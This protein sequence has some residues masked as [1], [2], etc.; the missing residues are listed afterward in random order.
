MKQIIKIDS[1]KCTGCGLCASTCHQ[2]AIVMQD[3]KAVLSRDDYCDGL[4]RCLGVCPS[5]AINFETQEAP[6]NDAS[7]LK[8]WPI[9]IKL[10]PVNAA[11]FENANLLIAADCAAYAH[12]NFHN[13]FMRNKITLIGC[14][15]LDEGD[16]SEKL[17]EILAANDIKSLT[18]A[19]MS[20]PCCRGI[21]GAVRAALEK[22]GKAIPLGVAVI[23]TDGRLL[24]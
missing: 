23:G 8:Q 11:Y 3:G 24:A 4:G 22:C 2:S 16:Y 20:V 19:R 9:Q 7:A 21:E 18:V 1:E 13:D 15:K 5:G 6:K 10:V 14:P 12:G 17:T